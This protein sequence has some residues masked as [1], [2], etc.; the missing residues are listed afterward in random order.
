MRVLVTGAGGQIGRAL[1][2]SVPAGVE[3]LG[4][5]HRDLDLADARG[6]EECLRKRTPDVVVNAAAYTAV[7]RAESEP[8]A[9]ATVNAR[10]PAYLAGAA[11]AVRARVIHLST[12]FVFDGESSHPYR[13]ESTTAPLSVYGRTKLEGERAVL[14]TYPERALILRT[15]WV[16]DAAGKNFVCTMLRLM[17]A[18][19]AVR[20]VSDQVGSPTAAQSVAEVIWR[21]IGRPDLTGIHHWTDAGVASWY[22]LAIAVAEEAVPLGLLANEPTVT[23]IRSEEYPTPARRPA[24]SVLDRSS[25]ASVAGPPVH[26]RKMLRRVLEQIAR[27]EDGAPEPAGA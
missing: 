18:T 6:L 5:T 1:L 14:A 3:V 19:G 12:D 13:P 4:L 21:V 24:Y 16:Y 20:V 23:P 15:A 26:W 25:L 2:E 8:E 11:R 9:A 7:D 10:G 17:R 22:D 27:A